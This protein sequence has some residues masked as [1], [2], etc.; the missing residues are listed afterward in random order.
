[1]S[2]SIIVYRNPLEAALWQNFTIGPENYVIVGNLLFLFF[3]FIISFVLI[4][5]L[6]DK[7]P[8][9]RKMTTKKR[10]GIKLAFII[11]FLVP[12]SKMF[13]IILFTGITLMLQLLTTF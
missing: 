4:D 2:D 12:V 5:L 6:F 8:F 11:I 1:M 10:D 3:G 9:F 7:I 13:K